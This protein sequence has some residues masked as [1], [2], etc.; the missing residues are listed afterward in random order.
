MEID[1]TLHIRKER[2]VKN[3][4]LNGITLSRYNVFLWSRML[5]NQKRDF[6]LRSS[7]SKTYDL[8][9]EGY[10]RTFKFVS[11]SILPDF[12]DYEGFNSKLSKTEEKESNEYLDVS[13]TIGGYMLFPTGIKLNEPD[14]NE[15]RLSNPAIMGRFDLTLECIR[16]WYMHKKS[17]LYD[18]IERYSYFF[19][20]F[21]NF[22]EYANYFLLR[23]M[24]DRNY[25]VVFW[26]PFNR[27]KGD[28]HF[29]D[30][31]EYKNYIDA[32]NVFIRKRNERILKLAKKKQVGQK[33]NAELESIQE[34]F[35]QLILET[36]DN[37]C[38]YDFLNRRNKNLPK[39]QY[40]NYNNIFIFPIMGMHGGLSYFLTKKEGRAILYVESWS[41]IIGGSETE[42]EITSDSVKECKD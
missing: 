8:V 16:R 26:A 12:A 24:L 33:A 22:K 38:R 4:N 35:H 21:F 10:P 3:P 9:Y 29:K 11:D 31:Q 30:E 32:A 25:R 2:D 27:F 13:D 41:R 20:L 19:D 36:A 40:R 23:D 42:Y 28:F 7:K 14:L 17:P 15:S 18:E 1:T 6:Q 34:K 5:K 37:Y 39:I